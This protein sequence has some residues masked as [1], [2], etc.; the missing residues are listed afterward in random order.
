MATA[1][2]AQVKGNYLKRLPSN[3]GAMVGLRNLRLPSNELTELP[4][5]MSLLTDLV[6]QSIMFFSFL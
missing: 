2:P 5:S 1:W 4:P 6:S 3:M